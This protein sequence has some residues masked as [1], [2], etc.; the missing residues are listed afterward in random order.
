MNFSEKLKNNRKWIKKFR[1]QL[2]KFRKNGENQWISNRSVWK[3][4]EQIEIGLKLDCKLNPFQ[5]KKWKNSSEMNE[6]FRI[7]EEKM[8][9]IELKFSEIVGKCFKYNRVIENRFS[10]DL[11]SAGKYQI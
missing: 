11:I 1:I 2:E 3:T 5:L 7:Q 9:N 6:K 4:W 10:I 8:E